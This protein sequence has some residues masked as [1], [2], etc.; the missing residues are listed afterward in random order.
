MNVSQILHNPQLVHYIDGIAC[1]WWAVMLSFALWTRRFWFGRSLICERAAN[2]I[3]YWA[4]VV[5]F[6]GATFWCGLAAA[7][8]WGP[9]N[10]A[11][12]F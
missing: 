8:G 5:A 11:G 2:P 7:F 3:A 1:V 4:L 9:G 6:V 10:V 12:N